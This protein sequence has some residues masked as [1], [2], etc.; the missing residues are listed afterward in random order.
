[1]RTARG[2]FITLEGGEGAGKSTHAG[3]LAA[4]LSGKGVAV[5][6]TRE[7]GGSPR[8][9][10]IRELLLTGRVAPFGAEAE[11]I[12]F[13]VARADHMSETIRPALQ[14]G[15]W[16]VCDRFMDSSRAYQGTD[17]VP[18][19]VLD[20]LEAI[21]VGADRPDLTL[22][23]DVPAKLGLARA[24][25]RGGGPDRFGSDELA[26]HERRRAVFLAIAEDEPQRCV[27]I[28]ADRDPDEVARSV[29]AS[30]EERLGAYLGADLGSH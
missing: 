20:R 24:E 3:R 15:E 30:V 6:R 28:D 7:P 21:A 11:A 25:H 22:I 5:C 16:V 2:R 18:E 4:W 19:A 9:E 26:V 10:V 27:V 29:V 17:G 23:L 14:R 8:A 12:L 13:A 1:V